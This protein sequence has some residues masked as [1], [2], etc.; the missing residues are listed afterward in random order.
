V[1]RIINYINEIHKLR[2]GK[3]FYINTFGCQMN[4]RDSLTIKELLKSMGYVPAQNMEDADI[5][6]F[7]T[8][9][10]R[11]NAENKVYGNL[12]RLKYL[13]QTKKDLKVVVAGCM[14]QQNSVI[15]K[16]KKT[17]RHVDVIFGTFNLHKFPELLYT[18]IISG[19]TVIDIWKESD[20]I[21][22][23]LPTA[24]EAPH[25][26]SVNIMFVCNNFCSY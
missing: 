10:V 4:V 19:E 11:E 26:A 12:G 2:K 7:N 9:C 6:V 17:H 8:C 18:N 13:K 5:V 24:S 22:E 1:N 21:T 14:V 16:I 20:E 15:E 25:K 3:K 23:G